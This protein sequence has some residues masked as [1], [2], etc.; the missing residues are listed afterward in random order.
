MP[1]SPTHLPTVTALSPITPQPPTGTTTPAP[2]SPPPGTPI[3]TV[4]TVPRQTPTPTTTQ[5]PLPLPRRSAGLG[6]LWL[7][8]AVLVAAAAGLAW[9]AYSLIRRGVT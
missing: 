8:G 7:V 2:P 5:G 9:L 4:L 6:Q 1:V 3:V